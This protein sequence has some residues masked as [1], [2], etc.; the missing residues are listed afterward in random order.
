M[1]ENNKKL[2]VSLLY[3]HSEYFRASDI[4]ELINYSNTRDSDISYL[5]SLYNPTITFIVSLFL[6]YLGID[7]MMI[8]DI[9][10]GIGKF[11]ITLFLG[12]LIIPSLIVWIIDLCLIIGNVKDKNYNKVYSML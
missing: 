7:R 11:L 2:I 3:S 12:W 8:G 5:P 1:E 6:G 4:N 9:G 10:W